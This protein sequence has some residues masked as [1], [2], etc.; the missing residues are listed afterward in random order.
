MMTVGD[1]F[2]SSFFMEGAG[3]AAG[4]GGMVETGALAGGKIGFGN[5]TIGVCF[6]MTRSLKLFLIE[7]K[8][9]PRYCSF[10]YI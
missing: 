4:R 9:E 8:I 5:S 2:F 1:D 3:T 6:G 7:S 10:S